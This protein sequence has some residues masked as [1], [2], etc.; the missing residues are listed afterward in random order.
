M[1]ALHREHPDV[2]REDAEG[3]KAAQAVEGVVADAHS[4]GV[5]PAPAYA[6]S[7]SK[8]LK[9]GRRRPLHRRRPPH[10]MSDVV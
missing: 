8:E 5:L 1:G 10:M 7:P 4:L 2:Q 9:N 6:T 3:G